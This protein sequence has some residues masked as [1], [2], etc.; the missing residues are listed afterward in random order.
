[1]DNRSEK[2]DEVIKVYKRP[3][4]LNLFLDAF[5]LAFGV[6]FAV[7]AVKADSCGDRILCSVFSVIGLGVTLYYLLLWPEKI[8]V[9][10]KLLIADHVKIKEEKR[11]RYVGRVSIPWARI[12]KFWCEAPDGYRPTHGFLYHI[13]T[14][15]SQEYLI[16]RSSGYP[17]EMMDELRRYCSE[18][19]R[20]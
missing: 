11:H 15:D 5:F 3:L 8:I 17:E 14:M 20:R 19:S 4:W 13:I 7:E 10:R 12:K 18:F 6:V 1:M 9:T 16:E 2:A